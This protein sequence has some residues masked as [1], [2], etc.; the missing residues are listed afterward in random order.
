MN[1]MALRIGR[2]NMK[3]K[4]II[5]A[6]AISIIL[7]IGVFLLHGSPPS[8]WKII[9]RGMSFDEVCRIIGEPKSNKTD[10]GYFKD[11]LWI[12]ENYNGYWTFRIIYE[13]SGKISAGGYGFWY[14]FI[15]Q[16]NAW[17]SRDQTEL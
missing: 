15:G 4:W 7:A 9:H 8:D 17:L 2:H 5:S 12:N 3:A 13:P 14:K 10:G 1:L 6:I 16:F 11:A